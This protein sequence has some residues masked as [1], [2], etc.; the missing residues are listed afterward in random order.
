MELMV[1]TD[2][3]SGATC[4]LGGYLSGKLVAFFKHQAK[5]FANSRFTYEVG[6]HAR[7]FG[8]EESLKNGLS[9][10]KFNSDPRWK[11]SNIRSTSQVGESCRSAVI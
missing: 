10:E 5:Y 9:G 2:T 7:C 8:F 3:N 4:I 11:F 1:S 6:L